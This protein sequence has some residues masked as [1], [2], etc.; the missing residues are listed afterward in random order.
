MVP[1]LWKELEQAPS[2]RAFFDDHFFKEG[3]ALEDYESRLYFDEHQ[4]Q[5]GSRRRI[6]QEVEMLQRIA[7][8]SLSSC[9]VVM[10]VYEDLDGD[11]ALWTRFSACP[12]ET[13]RR[14]GRAR[15]DR[16]QVPIAALDR[17]RDELHTLIDAGYWHPYAVSR[18]NL[19]LSDPSGV[20]VVTN[21]WVL[22]EGD[23]DPYGN[24]HDNPEDRDYE[25]ISL[26]L[27]DVSLF[28]ASFCPPIPKLEPE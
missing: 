12:G 18:K 14:L 7:G 20:L 5:F 1:S 28:R 10:E 26:L 24:A 2:V 17:L 15:W 23:E 11:S 9:P 13:L 25:R 8:L 21:W 16:H 19:R 22:C 3:Q 27:R 4:I 6:Q